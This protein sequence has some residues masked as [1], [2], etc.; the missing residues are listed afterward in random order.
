M[1]GNL[2][3]KSIRPFAVICIRASHV[4]LKGPLHE[5][6]LQVVHESSLGIGALGT[7][8]STV[9]IFRRMGTFPQVVMEYCS[10]DCDRSPRNSRH[11][12]T[13]VILGP[14]WNLSWQWN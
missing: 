11:F 2:A 8:C 7:F 12:S 1:I 3:R 9:E 6:S 5:A 10:Q 4:L 13:C 14:F